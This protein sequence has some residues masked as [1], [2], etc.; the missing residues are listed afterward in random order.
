[1]IKNLKIIKS[2]SYRQKIIDTFFNFYLLSYIFLM[3]KSIA[4]CQ[5]HPSKYR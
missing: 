5:C 3:T 2:Y 1:M 4:S